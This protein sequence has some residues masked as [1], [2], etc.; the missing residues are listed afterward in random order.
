MITRPT[1]LIL[2]AG[3]TIP[4]GFPS[5]KS[6]V[7]QICQRLKESETKRI[8]HSILDLNNSD[9][10]IDEFL[11]ALQFSGRYSIDAFLEHR[12]EFIPIG[13]AAIA[14]VLIP[15]ENKAGLFRTGNG[16]YRY[17]F[18]QMNT[19]F[20]EFAQNKLSVITY[21]YDRSFEFYLLTAMKN[22]YS[23]SFEE[24]IKQ[25]NKIPLI[26]LHGSLGNLVG[27]GSDQLDY[28]S[29]LRPDALAVAGRNIRVIHE[30]LDNE[31]QF[32]E[33]NKLIC[34]AEIICFL[35][36]GYDQ[37]NLDRLDINRMRAKDTKKL[38]FGTAYEKGQAERDWIV[39]Y[40]LGPIT[41]GNR[42]DIIDDFIVDYPILVHP[43]DKTKWV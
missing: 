18:N 16:W 8:I 34:D 19:E 6:L 5:G 12:T 29:K 40:F 26:H 37:I 36:F 30:N 2:G 32:L 1:V 38:I 3:S 11:K 43:R 20:E 23:K 27:M 28:G 17:L 10:I 4:Y 7:E 41:L 33:A 13:K 14:S 35:G 25:L 22:S 31:P 15:L 21:N 24:C 39:S 9:T 42:T